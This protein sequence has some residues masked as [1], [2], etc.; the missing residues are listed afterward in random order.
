MCAGGAIASRRM[1]GHRLAVFICKCNPVQIEAGEFWQLLSYV[2]IGV[3]ND[4]EDGAVGGPRVAS[5]PKG[6]A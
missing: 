5:G 3:H 1:A 2:H 4:S 6:E